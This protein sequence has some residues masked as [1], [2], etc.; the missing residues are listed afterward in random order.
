MAK[1]TFDAI[2]NNFHTALRNEV[3]QYFIDKGINPQGNSTLYVKTFLLFFGVVLL[4]TTL[5]FFT[6]NSLLACAAL[7]VLLG[8]N[9][10]L[11]GF[12]VSHD[13]CHGSY[14]DILMVLMAIL[15]KQKCCVWLLRKKNGGFIN[16]NICIVWHYMRC[17]I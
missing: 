15:S 3:N 6:P 16:T 5:V 8:V 7:C 10:A 14:S 13:A 9:L 2:S 17:R 1:V 11:I 12:N 4:Y